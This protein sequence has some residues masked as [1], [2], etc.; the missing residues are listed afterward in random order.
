MMENGEYWRKV[1]K[2]EGILGRIEENGRGIWGKLREYWGEFGK[3]EGILEKI[4]GMLEKLG[5]LGEF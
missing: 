2:I 4:E 1:R 5:N 3:I